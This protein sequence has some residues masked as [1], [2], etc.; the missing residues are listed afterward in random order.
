MPLNLMV[1]GADYSA[2]NIGRVIKL[3]TNRTGLVGEYLFGRNRATSLVNGVDG[4][5][6]PSVPV[7]DPTYG[8]HV[9]S[10]DASAN[11][12]I[13]SGLSDADKITIAVVC[14]F[15]ASAYVNRTLAGFGVGKS[16]N[17]YSGPS[18]SFGLAT[19]ATDATQPA[20]GLPAAPTAPLTDPRMIVSR[21]DGPTNFSLNIDEYKNGGRTQGSGLV[22]TVKNRLAEATT[23]LSFGSLPSTGSFALGFDEVAALVWH[24]YL[25]DAEVLAMYLEVRTVL[26]TM[27]KTI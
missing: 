16:L 24:R 10:M 23:K 7:A 4:G 3:T 12:Y 21:V 25:S 15:P 8:D 11:K 5:T 6:I 2:S 13:N 9:A 20:C 22:T 18:S 17:I 1:T 19:Q 27:G 26:A 14:A